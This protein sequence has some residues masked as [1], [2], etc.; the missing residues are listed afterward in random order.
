M[1]GGAIIADFISASE[2]C[3]EKRKREPKNHE[4]CGI[5]C[6]PCGRWAADIRDPGKGVRL[7]FGSFATAEEAAR[8]Y[9]RE[10][11]SIRGFKSNVNL[12]NVESP[13]PP[14][15]PATPSQRLFEPVA[16]DGRIPLTSPAF[17]NRLA[18]S[19]I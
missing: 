12:P 7:W 10:A 2:L 17:R 13:L 15:P 5:R 19:R 3:P 11:R 1:C 9:D 18:R 4:H 16:G 6:C 14:S 8:T